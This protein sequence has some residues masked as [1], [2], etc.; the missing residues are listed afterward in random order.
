MV[1]MIFLNA[2]HALFVGMGAILAVSS[3]EAQSLTGYGIAHD[4]SH[5]SSGSERVTRQSMDTVANL[6][7]SSSFQFGAVVGAPS[8]L[9][10]VAGYDFGP[11]A[12]RCSGGSW[13]KNWSGLQGGLTYNVVRSSALAIGMTAFVGE[14]R[15][16][17]VVGEPGGQQRYEGLACDCSLSGFFLQTGLANGPGEYAS[18]QFTFQ[19]GYLWT[20]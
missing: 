17:A 5:S 11:I 20:L 12:V 14:F 1:R 6:D 2:R 15:K 13:G 9:G 7:E 3:L 10:L 18:T 8:G 19:F 16:S 4:T